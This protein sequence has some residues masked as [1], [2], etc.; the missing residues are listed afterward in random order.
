LKVSMICRSISALWANRVC[1]CSILVCIS[2][3]SCNY[4]IIKLL[5]TKTHLSSFLFYARALSPNGLRKSKA[6]GTSERSA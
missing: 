6:G 1:N 4:A 2:I 3:C 5:L